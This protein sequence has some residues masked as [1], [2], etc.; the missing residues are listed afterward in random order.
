MPD[1][2]VR[3]AI[4]D[5]SGD[6]IMAVLRTEMRDRPVRLAFAL[7]LFMAAALLMPSADV[8]EPGVHPV[9]SSHLDSTG[10]AMPVPASLPS[11]GHPAVG[12]EKTTLV[13]DASAL[14]RFPLTR[15]RMACFP[16]NPKTSF[17][18]FR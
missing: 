9:T 14:E 11:T 1:F 10:P 3:M 16:E 12:D 15:P 4:K 6:S 5:P 17:L 8:H 2:I 13:A 18:F 7:L